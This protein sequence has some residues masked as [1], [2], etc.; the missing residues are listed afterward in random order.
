MAAENSSGKGSSDKE[1][2]LLTSVAET[3]GSTLGTLVA[4]AGAAQKSLST[5]A[6]DTVATVKKATTKVRA[7][8]KPARR[9]PARKTAVKRTVKSAPRSKGKKSG[10][11]AKTAKTAASKKRRT[12][13]R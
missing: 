12:G 11:A 6:S 7:I 9:T 5:A 13:R 1:S 4:R 3:I 10:K 2:G 8:R